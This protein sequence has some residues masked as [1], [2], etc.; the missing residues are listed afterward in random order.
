MPIVTVTLRAGKPAAFKDAVLGAV[1]SALVT[2]GV[3]AHDR[4]HRVIEL[5]AENFRYDARY[6]DLE[7]PRGPDFVLIEILLSVGR[8][9]KMKRQIVAEA[10]AALAEAP[11]LDPEQVMFCFEETRW[12]NWSFGGGR[13]IHV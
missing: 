11:K 3:P 5:E 6:P 9:V 12:E 1:H 2:A 10:L 7:R 4:F 13:F 8:S